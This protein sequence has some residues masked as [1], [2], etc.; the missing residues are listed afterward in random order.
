MGFMKEGLCNHKNDKI[1]ELR[2]AGHFIFKIKEN[3]SKK[4]QQRADLR[5]SV[6]QGQY[7]RMRQFH[8]AGLGNSLSFRDL[9]Q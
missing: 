5:E 7:A 6:A 4:N 3:K 2:V 1:I 9:I 8:P